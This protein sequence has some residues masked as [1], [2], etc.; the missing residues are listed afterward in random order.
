MSIK[1]LTSNTPNYLFPYFFKQ[2]R[3]GYKESSPYKFV[4]V[5]VFNARAAHPADVQHSVNKLSPVLA[6]GL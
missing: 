5:C 1:I 3:F 2:K 4:C 6:W